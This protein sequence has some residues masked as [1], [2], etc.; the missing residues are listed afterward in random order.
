M[1]T[2]DKQIKA[3]VAIINTKAFGGEPV[4]TYHK[5]RSAYHVP[6]ITGKIDGGIKG[7]TAKMQTAF[8]KSVVIEQLT[9]VIAA[10]ISG[11]LDSFLV[12]FRVGKDEWGFYF[13]SIVSER[14]SLADKDLTPTKLGL[15]GQTLKK[16][17]FIEV[18]NKGFLLAAN[19]NLSEDI[20]AL[21]KALLILSQNEG[22]SISI[23]KPIK[24]ALAKILAPDLKKFGKN[25]GEVLLA[26]WC[27]YNK[28]H[29]ESIF[30]PLAE[31]NPLAD[32]VVNFN[33][34]SK[35]APLNVSA[36]FE[37]G[38]NASVKSILQADTKPP[39][40]ASAD[41]EQAFNAVKAVAFG[42]VLQGLLDA[43]ILLNTKEYQI[44]Q[45]MYVETCEKL[46]KDKRKDKPKDAC[47]KNITL[48]TIA[49]VIEWVFY[50]LDITPS[51]K[52]T[53]PK[54]KAFLTKME[55]FYSLIP[56]Q[57]G[58][59]P[60]FTS[61]AKIAALPKNK[62]FHPVLYAFSVALSA[63]FNTE[64]KFSSVLNKAAKSIKAEQIYLDISD[65]AISI[66]VKVFSASKFKF[67]PGAYV[68]AADNT[69]MKVKML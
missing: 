48:D 8:G 23:N 18:V 57:S 10:K 64:Q 7:I 46:R 60:K 42:N 22:T 40:G 44:I 14:G 28:P 59:R 30:F 36:K 27:L 31:A 33:S 13:R 19:A 9:G 65:D 32:F 61:M 37:D 24:N 35:I 49:K 50:S 52:I 6:S 2:D 16:G 66:T 25:Y 54:Y 4:V 34:K 63:K 51:A 29:A 15:G 38:A 5:A 43:Q 21:G 56:G 41:E 26:H 58:G 12:K 67:A 39:K 55:P 1:Y 11:K 62:Y 20:L 69:R 53:Q 47:S 3:F 17:D 68:Y 45:K